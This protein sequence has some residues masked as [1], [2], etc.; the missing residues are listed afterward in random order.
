MVT[1]PSRGWTGV[2]FNLGAAGRERN[3]A[4]TMSKSNPMDNIVPFPAQPPLDAYALAMQFLERVLHS[5]G[6]YFAGVKTKRGRWRDTPQPTIGP[7]APTCSKPT[8]TGATPISLSQ[9][10]LRTRQPKSRERARTARIPDRDRLRRGP[11]QRGHLRD[12]GRCL[13]ALEAS[14]TRWGCRTQ[15]LSKAAAVCMSIGR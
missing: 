1:P 6:V 15:W 5:E 14:A 9:A 8:A 11:R 4:P 7:C 3:G 10:S 12:Q 2:H 13:E